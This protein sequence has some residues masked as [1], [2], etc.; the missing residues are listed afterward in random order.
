MRQDIHRP[1]SPDFDPLAYECEGAYDLGAPAV[2][3]TQDFYGR[4]H[5]SPNPEVEGRKALIRA[6]A[7]LGITQA[8]HNGE[9]NC[10]HCGAHLRYAALMR[11]GQ[12]WIWVGQDCLDNRFSGITAEEFQRLRKAAALNHER[13][14]TAIISAQREAKLLAAH[15]ELARL[16]DAEWLEGCRNPFLQ[17]IARKALRQDLTMRQIEA[18]T[19]AIER[20]EK[21]A[22]ER[23][24]QEEASIP[25]PEGRTDVTGTVVA[26]KW[27]Q[28]DFGGSLKMTVRDDRG[29]TVWGSVPSALEYDEEGN[30]VADDITGTRVT[31]TATLT[32]SD[33]RPSFAFFKRPTKAA[34][35]DTIDT[36]Q[37]ALV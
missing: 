13:E 5:S 7:K 23:A 31:F 2:L 20:S 22:A 16:F 17:D 36:R 6:L 3:Y 26:V 8:E 21:R 28:N 11:R 14:S 18:A 30:Y 9:W 35:L 37:P 19:E 25:A 29:F 10:G 4:W 34:Y 32:Q 33:D 1:S 12:E 27:H 15:P 24:A